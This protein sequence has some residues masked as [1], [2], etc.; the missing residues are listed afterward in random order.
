M[1]SSIVY[2]DDFRIHYCGGVGLGRVN[3]K[4][5]IDIFPRTVFPKPR[6]YFD[7]AGV[8]TGQSRRDDNLLFRVDEILSLSGTALFIIVSNLTRQKIR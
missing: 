7:T 3:R 5:A 1:I 4:Y 6:F 8:Q 2:C